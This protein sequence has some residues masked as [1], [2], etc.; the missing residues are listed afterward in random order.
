MKKQ[1]FVLSILALLL[2]AA[3]WGTLFAFK[4]RSF[5]AEFPAEA[6][7]NVT[8]PV[9]T[10]GTVLCSAAI[11]LPWFSQVEVSHVNAGDCAVASGTPETAVSDRGAFLRKSSVTVELRAVEPGTVKNAAFTLK[12]KTPGKQAAEYTCRIPEFQISEPAGKNISDLQ[13]A[14]KETP[15]KHKTFWKYAAAIIAVHIAGALILGA[16]WYF[17]LRR[18]SRQLSEWEKARRD[19]ELLRG[20]IE[21]KRITPENGFIRLTDLVRRYLERR[22]GLPATRRTTQEFLENFS[23]TAAEKIP[24]NSKPFLKNFLSAA[25]QV[26]FARA[27]ADVSLL[28]KA[29]ADALQLI[30]STRPAEEEKQNV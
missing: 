8:S 24:V 6:E 11:E 16:I 23:D 18:K 29:A 5:Q 13:L 17:K 25:D 12:V 20:D 4:C 10:G 22:F 2:C 3:V 27:S 19:L 14:E 1:I 30:D 28:S 26:K 15:P 7:V 21:E 9:P